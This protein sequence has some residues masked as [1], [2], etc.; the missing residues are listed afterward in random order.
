M[1]MDVTGSPVFKPHA[2]LM[3]GGLHSLWRMEKEAL[4]DLQD[5]INMEG[6]PKEV[7]KERWDE[8]STRKEGEWEG[9]G[10]EIGGKGI[11]KREERRE[12]EGGRRRRRGGGLKRWVGRRGGG[13][14][15]GCGGGGGVG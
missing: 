2:M 6:L 11:G 5:V 8:E 1:L 4:K 13:G 10:G 9:G 14:G 15:C 12:G 3:R 7:R